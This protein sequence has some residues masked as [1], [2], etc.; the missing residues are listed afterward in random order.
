V[1][2]EES[3]RRLTHD[4][5]VRS[6]YKVL[7]AESAMPA[8]EV[9][10]QHRGRIHLLLTDVVMLGMNGMVLA[11]KLVAARPE[12]RVLYMSG[13]TDRGFDQ[14]G[15]LNPGTLFLQKPYTH[16]ALIS[17]VREALDREEVQIIG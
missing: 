4:L 9:A 8:L 14:Q 7:Q 5:L 2:D 11:E 15:F 1:E 10:Q 17:K 16:S 6:G 3:L 12:M 13:Y